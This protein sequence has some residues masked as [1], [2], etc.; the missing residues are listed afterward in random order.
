MQ[1]DLN[2]IDIRNAIKNIIQFVIDQILLQALKL[3]NM[4][5]RD[6]QIRIITPAYLKYSVF[7]WIKFIRKNEKKILTG[8]TN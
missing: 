4:Q 5:L 6:G 3:E 1:L 2:N 7:G 8:E